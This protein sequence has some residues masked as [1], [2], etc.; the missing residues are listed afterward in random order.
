LETFSCGKP[1]DVHLQNEIVLVLIKNPN[2]PAISTVNI[3][4]GNKKINE[5]LL[6]MWGAV[7]RFAR[8]K[9]NKIGVNSRMAMHMVAPQRPQVIRHFTLVT[10]GLSHTWFRKLISLAA[11]RV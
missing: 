9:A 1:D 7:L 8:L 3:L 4:F 11:G 10:R 5:S 6:Q 2:S